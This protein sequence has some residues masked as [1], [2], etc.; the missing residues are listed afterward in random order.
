MK[1]NF[2][3]QMIHEIKMG[4]LKQRKS[5]G[6]RADE[7][8]F[9]LSKK[10]PVFSQE[11]FGENCLTPSGLLDGDTGCRE[12]RF[13]TQDDAMADISGEELSIIDFCQGNFA[14]ESACFE[15]EEIVDVDEE[16]DLSYWRCPLPENGEISVYHNPNKKE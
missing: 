6:L 7:K 8:E 12:G 9:L 5:W 16:E 1:K 15:H 3:S 14:P 13:I 4:G 10:L 2:S 11:N